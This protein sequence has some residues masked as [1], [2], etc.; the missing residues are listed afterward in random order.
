MN[1]QTAATTPL[2]IDLTLTDDQRRQI[3]ERTGIEL[4]SVGF[5]SAARRVRY[6]L[7]DIQLYVTQ[8]VFAPTFPAKRLLRAT[9]GSVEGITDPL[10][11]DVATGSGAIAL[12][13]ATAR[14]DAK[15]VAT[16]ISDVALR[17]ARQNRARLGVRNVTFRRGSLLSPISASQR[18]HV[19]AIAANVPYVPPRLLLNAERFFPPGTAIGFG[20]DGLDL[21]RELARQATEVLRLGGALVLQLAGYQWSV[22]GEHLVRLGYS[23]PI[24]D[25]NSRNTAVIG[26]S[27]LQHR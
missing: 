16:E 18:G 21:V 27:V 17:C 26:H 22:M 12:A 5:E 11:V 3:A 23:S 15:V 1:T 14:P 24:L 19:D 6:E 2:F 25:S 20:E 9:L 8:G 10:I 13:I 7:G 4:T